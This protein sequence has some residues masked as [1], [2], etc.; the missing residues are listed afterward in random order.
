MMTYHTVEIRI[1]SAVG[2][3]N[4]FDFH[5]RARTVHVPFPVTLSLRFIPTY[6]RRYAVHEALKGDASSVCWNLIRLLVYK[7]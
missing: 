2:S 7:M 5:L 3:V 1:N 4:T 6:L